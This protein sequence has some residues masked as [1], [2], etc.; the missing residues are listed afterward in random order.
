MNEFEPYANNNQFLLSSIFSQ[1]FIID[2]NLVTSVIL[3][4]TASTPLAAMNVPVARA[5]REMAEFVSM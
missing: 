5:T 4:Q 2:K 1:R 3:V